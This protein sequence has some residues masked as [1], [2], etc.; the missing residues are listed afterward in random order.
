MTTPRDI[1]RRALLRLRVIDALHPISAEEAVDGLAYLNDMMAQ[2]PAN[3]VDTLSPTF[4]LDDTFVFF[5]PPRLID[6]HTMESLTYAGTW[7]ASTNTP[8]LAAGSGTEGTVYRVSV[9]GTTSLDGI[10]SWS[11][12]DFIVLGRTASDTNSPTLTWQKGLS[13]ARHTSGVIALLAQRLAEDFG[14]DVLALRGFRRA[15]GPTLCL[16]RPPDAHRP[17]RSPF[18]ISTSPLRSRRSDEVR[19][20]LS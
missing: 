13:S 8:T 6:S 18:R 15:A 3:G 2:W 1:V 7:N 12:D 20:L 17:P 10:A 16:A 14:K 5:V 11:V 4:A 19:Q 9:A